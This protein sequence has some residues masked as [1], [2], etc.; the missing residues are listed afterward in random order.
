MTLPRVV[1]RREFQSSIY[2]TPYRLPQITE[3]VAQMIPIC[4]ISVPA[5]SPSVIAIV[6]RKCLIVDK[7]SE[8]GLKT[9]IKETNLVDGNEAY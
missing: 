8:E 5:Q 4:R 6:M 1:P 3:T 7:R 2:S 9:S